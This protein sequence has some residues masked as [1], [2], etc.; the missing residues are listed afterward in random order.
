MFL[1]N[2]T[3]KEKR[4]LPPC[5]S[6][7]LCWGFWQLHCKFLSLAGKRDRQHYPD[8]PILDTPLLFPLKYAKQLPYI[9]HEIE[10]GALDS[11][12]V[13]PL[14]SGPLFHT[15][16]IAGFDLES[17]HPS[18]MH[19]GLGQTSPVS[20]CVQWLGNDH[21]VCFSKRLFSAPP[22]WFLIFSSFPTVKD[23]WSSQKEAQRTLGHYVL[24]ISFYSS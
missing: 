21:N 15:C 6:C 23:V 5:Y 19:P 18:S 12:F 14:E 4:I 1:D 20:L 22:Y 9:R 8:V 3:A 13:C 16:L 2:K 11:N 24:P 17:G 7:V 10:L